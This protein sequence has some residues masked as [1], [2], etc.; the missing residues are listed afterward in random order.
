LQNVC[1]DYGTTTFTKTLTFTML[2]TD[3]NGKNITKTKDIS[4]LITLNGTLTAT[5]T[6]AGITFAVTDI[7]TYSY[8]ADI[9]VTIN[10]INVQIEFTNK[11]CVYDA[12]QKTITATVSGINGD[13]FECSLLYNGETAVYDA[14]DYTVTVAD[15][16]G[17]NSIYYNIPKS[18]TTGILKIT[19]VIYT[20]D[21]EANKQFTYNKQPQATTFNLIKQISLH[22]GHIICLDCFRFIPLSSSLFNSSTIILIFFSFSFSL[23]IFTNLSS[24]FITF[25]LHKKYKLS[26]ST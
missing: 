17:N 19:P 18:Y 2:A 3:S 1:I 25:P 24:G 16:I 20:L 8:N 14:G 4:Y 23:R 10:P 7:V 15:I 6:T 12:T 5:A 21:V 11:E 9:T 22:I 13:S 26:K